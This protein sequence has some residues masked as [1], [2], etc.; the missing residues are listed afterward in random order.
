M[1]IAFHPRVWLN[2]LRPALT[3]VEEQILRFA[4]NAEVATYRSVISSQIDA[5]NYV[6]RHLGGRESFFYR[7]KS[8]IWL[9]DLGERV[10]PVRG[11]WLWAR[12]GIISEGV[13]ISIAEIWFLNGRLGSI[14]FKEPLVKFEGGGFV[15]EIININSIGTKISETPYPSAKLPSDLYEFSKRA[16]VAA[17]ALR[18][19]PPEEAY[20]V[21]LPEGNF[22]VIGEIVD[23]GAILVGDDDNESFFGV[24][25]GNYEGAPV[26]FLGENCEAA[27]AAWESNRAL[28][29]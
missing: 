20:R 22:F 10:F 1:Q 9:R 7:I 5:I 21:A 13:R 15:F 18:F 3:S 4:V 16:I 25:L 2:G 19:I 11:E 24:Y 26:R 27:V 6:Q 8:G 12:I 29:A 14:V 28:S 17:S 23:R